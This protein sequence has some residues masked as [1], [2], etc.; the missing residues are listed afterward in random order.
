MSKEL[1]D[2]AKMSKSP[3]EHFAELREIV[4]RNA[5]SMPKGQE[6]YNFSRKQAS[7]F[8]ELMAKR[9]FCDELKRSYREG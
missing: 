3:S 9:A 5:Q 7:Y 1:F 6:V 8:A 4:S 2:S